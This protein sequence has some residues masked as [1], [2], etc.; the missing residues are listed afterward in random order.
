MCLYPPK[1]NYTHSLSLPITFHT[2][3]IPS[4]SSIIHVVDYPCCPLSRYSTFNDNAQY[5][6]LLM[7]LYHRS[8]LNFLL[9]FL[10]FIISLLLYF[11][12]L[13]RIVTVLL[14]ICIFL[15][16]GWFLHPF[17]FS[18][19]SGTEVLLLS[20]IISDAVAIFFQCCCLAFPTT[21]FT[22]SFPPYYSCTYSCTHSVYQ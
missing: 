6:Y 3:N 8:I 9:L 4:C 10:F 16:L 17:I 14:Y 21:L 19:F 11:F 1:N 22:F 13:Q 18:I 5:Q 15:I 12:L 7:F 20:I 2:I